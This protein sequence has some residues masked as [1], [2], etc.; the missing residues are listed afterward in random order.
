VKLVLLANGNKH[1]VDS[2]FFWSTAVKTSI[3][4]M[5]FPV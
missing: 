3:R 1:E 5:Y 4:L 2:I